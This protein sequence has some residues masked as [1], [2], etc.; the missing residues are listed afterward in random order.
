MVNRHWS[1]G[2]VVNYLLLF[3]CALF[4]LYPFWYVLMYSFSPN[5]DPAKIGLLVWPKGFGVDGYQRVFATNDVMQAY[6]NTIFVAVVG[7]VVSIVMTAMAGYALSRRQLQGRIVITFIIFFTML[8]NGGIIPTFILVKRLGLVNTLWALIIPRAVNA[9]YLFIMRNF[10]G[11]IPDSLE[12]SAK[13][14][15]ANDLVIFA[16]II[17]PV[18]MSIFA[19]IILFY[20]VDYW[21]SFF[22]AIIYINERSKFTLQVI[23]REILIQFDSS[24]FGGASG[25]WSMQPSMAEVVRMTVV[26]VATGPIIL[27]YPFL[28]KYFIKGVLIG[29]IK[30]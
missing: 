1:V 29:S 15:G 10:L 5:V 18:S 2:R 30:G 23:L 21:N 28:Q 4:T 9:Y 19:T 27:V 7:A 8:F 26:I 6:L 12:E 17:V 13:L 25:A 14:D 22:D 3:I 11:S 20:M 16:R 24:R